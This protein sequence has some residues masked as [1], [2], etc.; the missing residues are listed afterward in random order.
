MR[1]KETILVVDDDAD[2]AD[3]L[4]TALGRLGYTVLATNDPLRALAAFEQDPSAWHAVISD[5]MMPMMRGHE[6]LKRMKKI[7]PSVKTILC[8]G[9]RDVLTSEPAIRTAADQTYV[10]PID[11]REIAFVLRILFDRR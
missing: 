5:E 2:V 6:M 9:S 7:R 10:K 1:G 3:V 11:V 8:S 4:V